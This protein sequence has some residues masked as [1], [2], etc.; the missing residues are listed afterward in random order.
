MIL[1]ACVHVI[2]CS[3]IFCVCRLVLW[4]VSLV[5][6]E[7]TLCV[8]SDSLWRRPGPLTPAAALVAVS[9]SSANKNFYKFDRVRV[10]PHSARYFFDGI[11]LLQFQLS[12]CRVV[13]L[14]ALLTC[15]RLSPTEG[16]SEMQWDNTNR[17]NN[18]GNDSLC[19]AR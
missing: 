2:V 3:S 11:F 17:S 13:V 14:N 9:A 10:I 16:L 7:R 8:P 12:D 6:I 19:N 15:E 1:R 5:P 4:I 18:K